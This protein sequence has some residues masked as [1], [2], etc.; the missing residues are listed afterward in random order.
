MPFLGKF[1]HKIQHYLFKVNIDTKLIRMCRIQW[2]CLFYLGFRVETPFLIKFG[3][4]IQ[5]C[6][7]KL[8][9]DTQTN[10]DMKNSI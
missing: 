10:S 3:L 2:G 5:N 7:F 6:Q 8:K 9:F 4:K 1:G